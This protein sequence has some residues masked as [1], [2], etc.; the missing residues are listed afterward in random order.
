MLLRDEMIW[1]L[2][3]ECA[4]TTYASSHYFGSLYLGQW[5]QGEFVTN[6]MFLPTLHLFP[7]IYPYI[8]P[9]RLKRAL[10]PQWGPSWK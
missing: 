6:S 2:E 5:R 10:L 3:S 7:F 1:I 4:G 8:I 9:I